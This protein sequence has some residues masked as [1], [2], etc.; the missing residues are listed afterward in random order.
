MR[1]C[2]MRCTLKNEMWIAGE[3]HR[4]AFYTHVGTSRKQIL[5]GLSGL[6]LWREASQISS[7]L[8]PSY[9]GDQPL[10][11]E[12]SVSNACFGPQHSGPVRGIA[13]LARVRDTG[14]LAGVQGEDQHRYEPPATRVGIELI[15]SVQKRW[16]SV[17]GMGNIITDYAR[18]A[19][20]RARA[21]RGPWTMVERWAA[22]TGLN[23]RRPRH[24]MRRAVSVA[25]GENRVIRRGS[26]CSL[27]IRPMLGRCSSTSRR[28]RRV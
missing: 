24:G 23:F 1:A 8:L 10:L 14:I 9:H 16:G 20:A 2:I 27:P 22:G 17:R 13:V 28:S 7:P 12:A 26:G 6:N 5:A 15:E 25:Q 18:A 11:K 19:C 21:V 3:P 4:N